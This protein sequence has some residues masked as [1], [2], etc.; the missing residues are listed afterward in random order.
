M[1]TEFHSP[2]NILS[3]NV[4]F[5]TMTSI[6]KRL[7]N[8]LRELR[9]MMSAYRYDQKLRRVMKKSSAVMINPYEKAYHVGN[10]V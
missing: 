10:R 5:A 3:T 2:M 9:K 8:S 7:Y 4:A 1:K 6:E